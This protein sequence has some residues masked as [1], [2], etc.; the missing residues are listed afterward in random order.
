MKAVR[1]LIICSVVMFLVFSW[2][3]SLV[4]SGRCTLFYDGIA[5][6]SYENVYIGA[7]KKIKKYSNGR[8][9]GKI[10]PKTSRGDYA[11]TIQADDTLLLATHQKLYTIDK[12]GQTVSVADDVDGEVYI[13]L[14]SGHNKFTS[15]D[16]TT[17]FLKSLFG[18]TK[19]VCEDGRVLF[20][21]PAKD[22]A[23]KVILTLTELGMCICIPIIIFKWRKEGPVI[24]FW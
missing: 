19:V 20:R 12:N 21:M 5:V 16:G 24:K 4:L 8:L 2:V 23:V 18:R 22:Y 17:Y 10:H 9:I 15:E 11:F 13:H 14:S 1:L 3:D 6:D 7:G